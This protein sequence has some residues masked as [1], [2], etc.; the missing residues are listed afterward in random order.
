MERPQEKKKQKRYGK[1]EETFK[2]LYKKKPE[3]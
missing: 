1:K 3:D 2:I